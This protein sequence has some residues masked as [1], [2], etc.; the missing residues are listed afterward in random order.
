[1]TI[2]KR[3]IKGVLI[4]LAAILAIL[5]LTV[6]AFAFRW[7]YNPLTVENTYIRISPC[8]Q[9]Q[10]EYTK[11]YI[12]RSKE[13]NTIQIVKDINSFDGADYKDFV[14][15]TIDFVAKNNSPFNVTVNDGFIINPNSLDFVVYKPPGMKTSGFEGFEKS[16]ADSNY[17][18]LCYKGDLS[19]EEF[20]EKV[21][22]IKLN[23]YYET[24]L[25]NSLKKKFN[26]SDAIFLA[27]DDEYFKL[28]T[29]LENSKR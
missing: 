22:D 3:I 1:M 9:E 18:I 10:I 27:S 26:L 7:F 15:V 25:F 23:F 29:D 6:A 21:K 13:D 17:S 11:D 12:E 20:L 19:T 2:V 16:F 5:I 28:Q 8:T 14:D 24:K 4:A